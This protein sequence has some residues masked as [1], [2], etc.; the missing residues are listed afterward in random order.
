MITEKMLILYHL[1]LQEWVAVPSCQE[2]LHKDLK[3]T[4]ALMKNNYSVHCGDLRG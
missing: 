4:K 1:A 2:Y 3:R